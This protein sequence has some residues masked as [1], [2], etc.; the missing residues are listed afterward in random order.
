MKVKN[1]MNKSE[2]L[3]KDWW[4]N[5]S[6]NFKIRLDFIRYNKILKLKNFVLF[7]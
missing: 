3:S 7:F 5:E 6:N 1:R 2:E 4:K